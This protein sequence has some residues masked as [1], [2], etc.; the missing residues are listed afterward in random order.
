MLILALSCTT[1]RLARRVCEQRSWRLSTIAM[2][3]RG[4]TRRRAGW[5]G[6]RGRLLICIRV[7]KTGLGSALLGH[8]EIRLKSVVAPLKGA[9]SWIS[10]EGNFILELSVNCEEESDTVINM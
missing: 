4:M 1:S 6:S 2:A 10:R 7:A 5:F 9:A 8:P 3:L